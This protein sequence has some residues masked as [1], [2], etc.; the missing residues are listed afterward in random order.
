M[1]TPGNETPQR[2]GTAN[3]GNCEHDTIAQRPTQI[4]AGTRK[5]PPHPEAHMANKNPTPGAQPPEEIGR[6]KLREPHRVAAGMLALEESLRFTI[7]ETGFTR[8]VGDWL[9]VNKKDGFD[10]QSC[11]WPSPDDHRHVFEFCENGVKALTSEATKK[12]ITPDFFRDHSIAELQQQSDNWLELQGRLVHPMVKLPRGTHYEAIEWDQAFALLAEELNALPTPNAAAFYT[13]GRTSNEAAFLYQL[14]ARQFGTNNLPD[15]SNMCHESSGAALNETIGIGKGCVTLEDF[16]KADGIFILGQN[17]GTNHPRMMTVLERAKTNGAKIV[18]INPMPE[19]GLMEVV[20]PN[21]QEYRNPLTFAAKMLFN[22]G[23]PLSDLWLPIRL[24]GDM[25]TMRGIMKEMLAEEDR[26]PGSVFDRAFLDEH[27]FGFEPF[28]R[29]LEATSWD[30]ILYGSGLTRDQIRHAARIAMGCKRIIACWAMGL[31]QHRNAVATIQEVMNFLLL[32][33]NIGRPGAGPCPVRGH[34]NVQGDRTMGIWERMND[35]FMEK[36]GREFQFTPPREHGTD[37]VETIKHMHDGKIRF[38]LG[39]GGNFLAA[40]PDTEY[41]AKA[42]QKCRLTAHVSTK[43]NRSHLITGEIALILPCLGRSEI[44]KQ[45]WGEQFVTVEDSMG[46]INPSRGHAEPASEHLLSEP[47]IVG[48]LAEATM[49]NRGTVDWKSL[50]ANYDRIRD[51]IDHVIPGFEDFNNRIRTDVFY[52]PNDPRDRRQ[53]HT[54]TGKATFIISELAPIKLDPGQ[55]LMM[56][57]RSH[58]QFNTTIYGLNDRYRGIYNGRRVVFMNSEDVEAAGLQ[59]GQLVDLTSHYEGEERVAR[60]FMVAPCK[61]ARGCTATYF[62]EANVLV[63]I[64]STALRSNTPTSKS[65][66]ISI[67]PSADAAAAVGDILR[68]ASAA[69]H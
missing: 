24:N 62:P 31:T 42:M 17:P 1:N 54:P 63:P 30:E 22:K 45:D 43:L 23:T 68:N 59:Q 8:G 25:A 29:H 2:R 39:M 26:V 28:V 57:V 13:S 36:L 38:F 50:V 44:D 47:A 27:T 33:G 67:K 35:D 6:A 9:K 69:S 12:K 41:T 21:P 56:T 20:N 19:P 14:F 61:I 32:G 16:E 55:Y 4:G 51:H 15:C 58:D 10:C 64:D 34:S 5:S 37:T 18:A 3:H 60:H 52:L 49:G 7:R 48:N 11:A 53:F 40:S 66:V 46:I 65:L